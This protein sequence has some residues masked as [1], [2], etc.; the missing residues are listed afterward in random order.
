MLGATMRLCVKD[1][2]PF[3]ITFS[4]YMFAFAQFGYLIFGTQLQT[5][6]SFVGTCEALF[7]F[8]LGDYDFDAF[9]VC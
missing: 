7:A 6:G 2:K 1:L 9:R 4:I 5:Y 3:S 8:T